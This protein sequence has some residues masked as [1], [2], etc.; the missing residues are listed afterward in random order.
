MWE[1]GFPHF[2]N[3]VI[4][5]QANSFIFILIFFGYKFSLRLTFHFDFVGVMNDTIQYG[6]SQGGILHLAVPIFYWQLRDEDEGCDLPAVVKY[7]QQ[8]SGLF[9]IKRISEPIVEYQEVCS[10][11]LV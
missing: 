8:V 7:L 4:S 5:I 3:F 10:C 1:K 11:Q 2:N 9:A 6:I